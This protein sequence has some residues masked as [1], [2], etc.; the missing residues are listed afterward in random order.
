MI[1]KVLGISETNG[2]ALMRGTKHLKELAEVTHY[3]NNL[4][5][6]FLYQTF[7]QIRLRVRKRSQ[8]G[9]FNPLLSIESLESVDIKVCGVGTGRTLATGNAW[10]K[11]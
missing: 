7:V 4:F 2:I 3:F 9:H 8:C 1:I 11:I 6:P 5:T 10:P